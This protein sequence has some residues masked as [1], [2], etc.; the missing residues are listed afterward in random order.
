MGI[1]IN[2]SFAQMI[3]LMSGFM[4][5]D[6]AGDDGYKYGRWPWQTTRRMIRRNT[7]I[8]GTPPAPEPKTPPAKAGE[9]KAEPK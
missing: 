5:L 1:I 7:G 4:G 6:A 9:P 3:D 8:E 2:G